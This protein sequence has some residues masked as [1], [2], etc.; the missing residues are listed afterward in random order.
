METKRRLGITWWLDVTLKWK[1]DWRNVFLGLG[2][3]ERDIT[4]NDKYDKW[5]KKLC[6]LPHFL[7]VINN[8]NSILIVFGKQENI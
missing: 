2:K 5:G 6:L 1:R 3:A 4:K 8:K 7:T